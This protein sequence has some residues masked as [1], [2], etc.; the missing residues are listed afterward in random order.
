VLFIII[1]GLLW[2]PVMAGE[3]REIIRQEHLVQQYK[4]QAHGQLQ[5]MRTAMLQTNLK[6]LK[7]FTNM[8]PED[9]EEIASFASGL[10][11]GIESTL[12][13]ISGDLRAAAG[14][15]AAFHESLTDNHDIQ[16]LLYHLA[17]A[18]TKEPDEAELRRLEAPNEENELQ[19]EANPDPDFDNL[20]EHSSSRAA[21]SNNR[22]A[23]T[24]R[25]A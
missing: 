1:P 3:L 19:S 18:I 23:R 14:V 24:N 4:I 17:D 21:G 2:S 6:M 5:L 12:R 15:S 20:A 22:P 10:V 11:R 8:L 13:E 9:K 25:S 7:G 16:D